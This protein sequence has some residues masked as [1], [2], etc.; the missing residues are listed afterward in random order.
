MRHWGIF[1][2]TRRAALALRERNK[3]QPAQMTYAPGSMEWN[4]AIN[5]STRTAAACTGDRADD[6]RHGLI[7]GADA[8]RDPAVYGL[9][10][11]V[12][13]LQ[14]RPPVTPRRC[15]LVGVREAQHRQEN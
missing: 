9:V 6:R 15:L 8:D 5:K 12:C 3:P 13:S 1:D 11:R 10:K 14:R 4:A 7:D 2:H